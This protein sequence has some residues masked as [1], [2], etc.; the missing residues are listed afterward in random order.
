M[1]VPHKWYGLPAPKAHLALL[2]LSIAPLVVTVPTNANIILTAA[3]CVYV[4]CWR[5][6]KAVPPSEGMSTKDAMKFPLIGSAVLVSLFILFKVLPKDLVNM[7]LTLYFVV[8]GAW[9]IAASVLP[10][11]NV[12]FPARL[13][14]GLYEYKGLRIPYIMPDPTDISVT[15]PEV[16]SGV[17]ALAFCWAYVASKHWFLNN[18]LGLAFSLQGLEHFSIGAVQ[19]GIILLCG[20][21]FY[22]IFWVFCT[23]V[24]VTVAKSFDAPIKLLFPRY[25]E[26]VTEGRPMAMLGLGDIVIPGIFV[27]LILRYDFKHKNSSYFYS[28]FSGYVA[29]LGTT[30]FVMN[31]FDAA[32]PALLYIV[33]GVLGA[34][35]LH[36]LYQR[37]FLK[38]YNHTEED[39]A[40]I[41]E[42]E[43]AAGI[44]EPQHG[45][46]SKKDS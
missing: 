31:Y 1:E 15:L 5:S 25:V 3:L 46:T 38:V 22:D 20:L 44:K 29:G 21:F 16:A 28:A 32:Q 37:E 34:V 12:L 33:P 10:F 45:V 2:L 40:T 7:V 11:I 36:A 43:E 39:A 23:P 24:M 42:K 19:T 14:E 27:A 6:V 17:V 30:I 35:G 13:Q 18:T 9:V 8:L 4:G 41:R 26:G